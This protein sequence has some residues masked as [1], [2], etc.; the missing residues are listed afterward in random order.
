VL[1]VETDKA[2]KSLE[3]FTGAWRRFEYKGETKVGTIVYD[4]YAH[5]PQK[6]RAAL[7]GAR[8]MFPNKKIK[9]VFQPH[10]FSRT[11]LLLN[12]FA[13]AFSDADEVILAPIFPAREKFDPTIS[14]EILAER[15]SDHLGS[16]TR[17]SSLSKE[18]KWDSRLTTSVFPA[19]V[20][21]GWHS[22]DGAVVSFPDFDSII[23]YLKS[24]LSPNDVLI[25]MGAGEQYKIGEALLN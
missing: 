21:A 9:V 15:I 8:E 1:G 18:E 5:N 16:R 11:K 6:V 3:T 13:T 23:S 4:D 22:D 24:T 20:K 14:S 2:L 10:L 19:L 25:T 12:E 7:Q 17:H